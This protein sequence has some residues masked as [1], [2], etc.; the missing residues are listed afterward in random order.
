MDAMLAYDEAGCPM[1]PAWPE[2]D[3]IVGNP[4]FQTFPLPWAPGMEPANDPR[5]DAIA[6]AA[7]DLVALRDRWLNPLSAA[8][9]IVR[10]RTLTKLYNDRPTWLANAH[11]RLNDAVLDAYG[12][13][14]DLG[15]EDIL[16]K[17]LALNL[18]RAGV[19]D[20]SMVPDLVVS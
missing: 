5:V 4:P 18:G 16:A 17:L 2:A 19:L 11:D 8:E 20:P 3:V 13:P 1:E 7:R 14:H 6:D 10:E 15:D 12:W 9:A